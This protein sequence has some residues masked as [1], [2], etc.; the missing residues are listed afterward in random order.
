V[1]SNDRDEDYIVYSYSAPHFPCN[2]VVN[3]VPLVVTIILL[4]CG[5]QNSG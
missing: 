4:M 5:T 3:T 1:E 2:A